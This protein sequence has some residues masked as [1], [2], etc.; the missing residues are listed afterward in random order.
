MMKSLR[1]LC[2]AFVFLAISSQVRAES[3][4]SVSVQEIPLAENRADE[5]VHGYVEYRFRITNRDKKP[6]H[7]AIQIP[8]GFTGGSS[9]PTLVRSTNE[10]DVPAESSATIS[11]LQPVVAMQSGNGAQIIIDGRYQQNPTSFTVVNSHISAYS[12]RSNETA[13]A[14]A[15]QRVPA[16]MRD[17][18]RTGVAKPPTMSS[19]PSPSHGSSGMSGPAEVN[20]WLANAPVGE[21]SENWL[22]YTRFDG[23]ILTSGEWKELSDEF[24]QVLAALKKYTEAGGMLSI[25][26]TD[27]SAPKEWTSRNFKKTKFDAGFGTVTAIDKDT[28]KAKPDIDPLRDQLLERVKPW[29]SAMDITSRGGR[30]YR[31]AGAA[32]GSMTGGETTLR[33]LPVVESYGVPVKL[34]MILIVVFA[35]LIGPVN[36]YVLSAL[37]RRIWLLWTVPVT[38]LVASILVLGVNFVQEG[39]IRQSSSMTTTI[40]DQRQGEATTIGYVGFYATL[41]P[42]GGIVFD[43]ET[44]VTA[45]M[46]RG[47]GDS[48]S[49]E[50]NVVGGGSQHFSRG[51]INARVPAYFAIRKAQSHRKERLTFDWTVSPPTATNGLGVDVDALV[52]QSPK[53]ETFR[54]EGLRAGQKMPLVATTLPT[55]A[56]TSPKGPGSELQGLLSRTIQGGPQSSALEP[57]KTLFPG[58]YIAEIKTWNPFVERGVDRMKP[59]RNS[60]TIYGIFD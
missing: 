59:Y 15:S 46:N 1:I 27:W 23:V 32:T 6:H 51:W 37:K 12:R 41:T 52:V 31:G 42:R 48:R 29:E 20:C 26:G 58:S 22:A 21:W 56:P 40:L 11:L 10:A 57:G 25:V 24:P 34:I 43:P 7:V 54:I 60:T 18:I 3:Y 35:I 44:E 2:L 19:A 14:F 33:A 30:S 49:L 28:A 39:F 38:S 4:G 13:N 45:C 53:G 17:L 5:T 36:I 9:S 8:S 47:Y 16:D 55:G 50:L